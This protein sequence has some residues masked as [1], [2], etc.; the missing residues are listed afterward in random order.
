MNNKK[1]WLK[2]GIVGSAI[3]L[4]LVVIVTLI[5]YSGGEAGIAY[6]H[7][8]FVEKIYKFFFSLLLLKYLFNEGFS[9]EEAVGII[10]AISFVLFSLIGYFYGST[11]KINV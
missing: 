1:Y 9:F 6:T 4:V 5:A 3:T 7:G 11:K 2:F 8:L 10:F